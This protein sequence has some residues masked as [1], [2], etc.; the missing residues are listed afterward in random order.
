MLLDMTLQVCPFN[1]ADETSYTT[2]ARESEL[3][4]LMGLQCINQKDLVM[5]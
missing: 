3:I 2:V 4:Q 1:K 5:L